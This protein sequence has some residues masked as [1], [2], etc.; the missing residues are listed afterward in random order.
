M[1]LSNQLWSIQLPFTLTNGNDGRGKAFWK[2]SNDRKRFESDLRLMG[3]VRKPFTMPVF[4]RVTRL[5][6]SRQKLWDFSSGFRGNW[7]EL[8]DAMVSCG[9]FFDDGPACIR[10]LV[11]EQRAATQKNLKPAVL[12]EVFDAGGE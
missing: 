1:T 2:S 12:V 11:F 7:K 3:L 5:L 6:G 9:W 10:G 4:L 8:E